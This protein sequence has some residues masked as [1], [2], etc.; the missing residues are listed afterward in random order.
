MKN[1][2][3]KKED[4]KSVEVNSFSA[5]FQEKMHFQTINIFDLKLVLELFVY[6]QIFPGEN[7]KKTTHAFKL[8]LFW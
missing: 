3:F 1:E 5:T 2:N 4:L 8:V 6:V 7:G